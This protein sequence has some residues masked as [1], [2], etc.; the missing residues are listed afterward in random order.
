MMIRTNGYPLQWQQA[1][2]EPWLRPIAF[3][4]ELAG[5]TLPIL[6]TVDITRTTMGTTLVTAL[7][8]GTTP[9]Q[10]PTVV[11]LQ[12]MDPMAVSDTAHA[13]ATVHGTYARAAQ[14]LMVLTALA[15]TL[16][17]TILDGFCKNPAR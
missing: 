10:G 15:D 13:I 4:G 8:P 2:S 14:L 12:H 1:F 17:H 7:V 9:I 3:I 5:I 6:I 11:A 16:K